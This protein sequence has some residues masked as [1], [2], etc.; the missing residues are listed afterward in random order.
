MSEQHEERQRKE[1]R[2]HIDEKR[3][4]SPNPLQAKRCTSSGRRGRLELYREVSGNR[5]D[6]RLRT[7]RR[8][9]I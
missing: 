9:C 1:V 7:V 2:I 4:E 5:E 6:R 8:W 3:H